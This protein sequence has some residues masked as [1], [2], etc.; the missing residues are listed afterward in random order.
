MNENVYMGKLACALQ[1]EGLL[2]EEQTLQSTGQEALCSHQ[3][4]QVAIVGTFATPEIVCTNSY[5]SPHGAG[6]GDHHFQVHNFDAHSILGTNYPKTTRPS[7]RT[8]YCKVAR[9][10][11]KYNT[12]LKQLL[13]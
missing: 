8:L 13:V 12:V 5:L 2:M 6:I 1:S 4:G 7:G 9:T 11:K 3:T 10:V